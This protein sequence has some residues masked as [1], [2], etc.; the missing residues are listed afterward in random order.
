MHPK[1]S[2]ADNGCTPC[3]PSFVPCWPAVAPCGT[4]SLSTHFQQHAPL[5]KIP[6]LV[7]QG[8]SEVAQP[9]AVQP[10]PGTLAAAHNSAQPQQT[11]VGRETNQAE[12]GLYDSCWGGQAPVHVSY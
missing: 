9:G 5:G 3:N 6:V 8:C 12:S 11:E 7:I 4:G 10:P 1:S 2:G